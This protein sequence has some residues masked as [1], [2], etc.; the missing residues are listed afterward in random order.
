[1]P[2]SCFLPVGALVGLLA[3]GLPSFGLSAQLVELRVPVQEGAEFVRTSRQIVDASGPGT[4]STSET[5]WTVGIR[6]AELRADGGGILHFTMESLVSVPPGTPG[7]TDPVT[8][9]WLGNATHVPF[10]PGGKVD[11]S[12]WSFPDGDDDFA[13]VE[14]I[15]IMET[16]GPV[17]NASGLPTGLP[18]ALRIGE[19]F[20]LGLWGSP[21][22]HPTA[23]TLEAVDEVD[24]RRIARI[25]MESGGPV[26]GDVSQQGAGYLRIDLDAGRLVEWAFTHETIQ[27]DPRGVRISIV[28]EERVVPRT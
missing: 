23:F 4:S 20:R 26:P 22:A 3:S 8:D 28:R 17:G 1:M 18:P 9:A 24:G 25:R 16:L 7:E 5:R 15:R 11:L 14:S 6:V 12:G 27:T 13:F 19:S 21:G 2:R 10:E